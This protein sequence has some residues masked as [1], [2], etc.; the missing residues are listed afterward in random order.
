VRDSLPDTFCKGLRNQVFGQ[1]IW[2]FAPQRVSKATNCPFRQVKNLVSPKVSGSKVRE[3]I[4]QSS[5]D[6]VAIRKGATDEY[7]QAY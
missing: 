1:R 2:L 3:N 7:C 4:G 5:D 6:L